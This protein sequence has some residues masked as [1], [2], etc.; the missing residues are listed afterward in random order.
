MC[1]YIWARST[2]LAHLTALTTIGF[3]FMWEISGICLRHSLRESIKRRH[4]N[5]CSSER[6]K[7]IRPW[8]AHNRQSGQGQLCYL[9]GARGKDLLKK[10]RWEWV[11][12][13]SVKKAGVKAKSHVRL[14]G[15]FRWKPYSTTHLYFLPCNPKILQA[16]PKTLLTDMKLV[17]RPYYSYRFFKNNFHNKAKEV[18]IKTRTTTSSHSLEDYGTKSTTVKW[19]FASKRKKKC[20]KKRKRQTKGKRR[21]CCVTRFCILRIPEL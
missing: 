4:L 8:P 7:A 9:T 17:N 14:T 6:L 21:D 15:K 3:V 10:A 13:D 20:K 5:C 12:F 2:R 11:R 19:S 16:V 1:L 18:C